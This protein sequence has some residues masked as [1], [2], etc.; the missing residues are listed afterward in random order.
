MMRTA[1]RLI[2]L[3]ATR[4]IDLTVEPALAE[5]VDGGFGLLSNY[6]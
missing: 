2:E 6:A 3:H 5:M 1:A 4:V